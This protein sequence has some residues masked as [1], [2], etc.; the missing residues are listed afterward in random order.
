M[1]TYATRDVDCHAQFFAAVLRE[2][3]DGA[4]HIF[5]FSAI[6]VVYADATRCRCRRDT[7]CAPHLPVQQRYPAARWRPRECPRLRPGHRQSFT[8]VTGCPNI[9]RR[10]PPRHHWRREYCNQVENATCSTV[11]LNLPSIFMTP[12]FYYVL[13]DRADVAKRVPA[14]CH[15]LFS[16]R[17]AIRQQDS[18]G[19]LLQSVPLRCAMRARRSRRCARRYASVCF[20]ATPHHAATDAD[21]REEPY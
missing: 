8:G 13:H 5:F 16:R 1:P 6:Y 4:C 15:G 12:S 17:H 11:C 18:A 20:A 14:R 2:D 3:A 19:Y 10:P 21:K 7:M 9:A